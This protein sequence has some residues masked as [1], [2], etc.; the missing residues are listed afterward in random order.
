MQMKERIQL[1]SNE[2]NNNAVLLPTAFMCKSLTSIET[3]YNNI[4]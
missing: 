4:E 2:A 1:P 3:Q